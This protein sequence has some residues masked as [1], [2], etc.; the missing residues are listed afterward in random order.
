MLVIK[1]SNH[2]SNACFNPTSE[3]PVS[4]QH[5]PLSQTRGRPSRTTA[6]LQAR[7]PVPLGLELRKRRNGQPKLISCSRVSKCT[8]FAGNTRI[9]HT[10]QL[11]SHRGKAPCALKLFL[12]VL[13]ALQLGLPLPLLQHRIIIVLQQKVAGQRDT[14]V[15]PPLAVVVLERCARAH[16]VLLP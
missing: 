1:R 7:S 16:A 15:G 10:Y 9:R 14:R 3:R 4:V 5:A 2:Q 11:A 8:M 6:L 12:L 13:V